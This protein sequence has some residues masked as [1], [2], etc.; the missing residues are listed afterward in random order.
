MEMNFSEKYYCFREINY[1][2]FISNISQL[3]KEIVHKDEELLFKMQLPTPTR[4]IEETKAFMKENNLLE[5]DFI[6]DDLDTIIKEQAEI[7]NFVE[8]RM[9]FI[10]FENVIEVG[11]KDN[12]TPIMWYEVNNTEEI[13]K[14]IL[15][16]SHFCCIIHKKDTE[17][18]DYILAIAYDGEEPSLFIKGFEEQE[19]FTRI[20]MKFKGI[21]GELI[22]MN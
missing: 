4:I 14:S 8:S 20:E 16:K 1:N 19:I 15:F 11:A 9:K 6:F 7:R 2:V 12:K 21:F 3:L 22:K 13:E 17:F 10:N 18:S 5:E